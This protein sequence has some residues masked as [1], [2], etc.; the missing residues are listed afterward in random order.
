MPC[1][2]T[3][4]GRCVPGLGPACPRCQTE[5]ADTRVN[6]VADAAMCKLVEALPETDPLF[7]SMSPREWWQMREEGERA[8]LALAAQLGAA[9]ARRPVPEEAPR[10]TRHRGG[11]SAPA[12]ASPRSA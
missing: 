6:V 3:V 2:H 5:V 11:G 4:C 12:A 7:I 10:R 1:D 9:R 8:V